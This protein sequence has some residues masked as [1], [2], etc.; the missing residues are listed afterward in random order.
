V[1]NLLSEDGARRAVEALRALC[2][3][4]GPDGWRPFPEGL[5]LPELAA[6][7]GQ[8]AERGPELWGRLAAAGLVR[9]RGDLR[10]LAPPWI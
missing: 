5:G 2:G 4:P 6:R 9:A 3:S 10:E 8:P 7:A 1:E